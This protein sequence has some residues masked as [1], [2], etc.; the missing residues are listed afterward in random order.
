MNVLLRIEVRGLADFVSAALVPHGHRVVQIAPVDGSME[1]EHHRSDVAII[2]AHPLDA[3]APDR[4][5]SLRARFGQVPLL[6]LDSGLVAR[7]RVEILEAGANTILTIPCTPAELVGPVHA[8]RRIRVA[9]REFAASCVAARLPYG[10]LE[11]LTEREVDVLRLLA[12]GHTDLEIGTTLHVAA[13]TA[14]FHVG[15]ILRKLLARNRAHA[16]ALGAL[17]DLLQ[18]EFA[19]SAPLDR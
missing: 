8:L 6:V 4:I 14:R 9:E 7:E 18:V 15:S 10:R 19:A 1:A 17:F 16:A 11:A 12:R 2:E 5:R 3:S 13:R